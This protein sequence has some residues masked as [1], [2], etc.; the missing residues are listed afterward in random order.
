MQ[1]LGLTVWF[2]G[3]S[4]AGK[5]TISQYVR[6]NLIEKGYRVEHLDGDVIRQTLTRELGFTKA[7]RDDNIRRVG[8]VAHLLTRNNVIVLVSVISP[9]QD[10]RNEVREKI[11]AF[12]EIYVKAPLEI[13]KKRDVKGLYQRAQAGEIKNFSGIDDPYEPPINPDLICNTNLESIE[14]S[15]GKVV[16]KILASLI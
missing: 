9:Y 15:A 13:C 12:I 7:D 1:H 10:I 6:D 14:E 4:G 5:T 2:T 11:G 8:F 3:L 16:Q